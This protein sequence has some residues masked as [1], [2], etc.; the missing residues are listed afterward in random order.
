MQF[1][2]DESNIPRITKIEPSSPYFILGGVIINKKDLPF[3]SS[4]LSSFCK[5]EFTKLVNLENFAIHTSDMFNAR[6]DF[7]GIDKVT[8][9]EKFDAFVDLVNRLPVMLLVTA[10]NKQKLLEVHKND[11]QDPYNIAFLYCCERFQWHL[12]EN[13][14]NNGEVILSTRGPGLDK[15][16]KNSLDQ[17]L[18]MGTKHTNLSR[19]CKPIFQKVD[20]NSP[21]QIADLA[22]YAVHKRLNKNEPQMFDKLK[23][24]F[25]SRNGRVEGFGLVI[26]PK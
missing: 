24:K 14:V 23:S 4:E 26:Y 1:F 5:S 6:G 25:R 22:C 11:A 9:N 13:N 18:F 12:Q 10:I 17:F 16:Y 15:L 8:L 2:A 19:I 20:I 21:L 7:S 3:V